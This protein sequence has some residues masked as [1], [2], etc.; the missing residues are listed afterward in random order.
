MSFC[1]NYVHTPG[2]LARSMFYHVQTIGHS[3]H[4]GSSERINMNS[5]LLVY[6]ISGRCHLNYRGQSHT[7]GKGQAFLISCMDYSYYTWDGQQP[8]DMYWM[9][10]NGSESNN[11]VENMLK[12]HG[13]VFTLNENSI[14][15]A[16]IEKIGTLF[17]ENDR[18]LDVKASCLIVEMLTELFIQSCSDMKGYGI[19]FVVDQAIKTMECSY[20]VPFK[21]ESLCNNL[22]ISKSHLSKLFKKHTNYSPYEYLLSCRLKQAKNLLSST[23]LPIYE[24][25]EKTGF[26][27]VS[28]FIKMFRQ[29]EGTT[30]LK[31]RK[32]LT[33]AAA[34]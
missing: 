5:Y 34:Y 30:P 21:L 6:T 24:I 27:S 12:N 7:I 29:M 22:A 18:L 31:Y 17:L 20:H 14:I 4:N 2:S 32:N 10:F 8:W 13:S 19:P 26:E 23:N 28:H 11:Y 9:R 33:S 3:I 25:A 1:W 16:N 15:P